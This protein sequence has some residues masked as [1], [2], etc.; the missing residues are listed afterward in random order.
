MNDILETNIAF[1]PE[2]MLCLYCKTIELH[3]NVQTGLN[4]KVTH[5]N[6]QYLL[7]LA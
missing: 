6:Y 3:C 1:K 2:Q 4:V 7:L 5:K